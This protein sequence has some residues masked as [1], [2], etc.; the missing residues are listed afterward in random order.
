MHGHS[1]LQ[2]QNLPLWR[3]WRRQGYY[4]LTLATL[5]GMSRLPERWGQGICVGLARLALR[6]RSRERRQA[7]HNLGLAFPHLS[8]SERHRLLAKALETLG[9]NL[10]DMLV[11]DRQA[12]RDFPEVADAGVIASIS[13]LRAHGRG[14]L[15][16]TGHL[17]CWELLGAYLAARLQ[18]LAVITGTVHNAPVDRLLQERRVRL[19]LRPMPRESDLRPVVRTLRRGGVVAVLLDQNTRVQ[20]VAVPFFGRPAPTPVGFAR[21]ALRYRVPVLPVA[22]GRVAA[23]HRISHLSPLPL[24]AGEGPA[25]VQLFLQRCNEALEQFIRRNPAEWV[26]FHDRWGDST[27]SAGPR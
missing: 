6:A 19:G 4:L 5:A 13:K 16:L 3:R 8:P 26:W 15:I 10:Y 18:G 23:G 12:R 20:N 27:G 17:G 9:R 11:L 7:W 24:P 14:V 25:A 21:L 22:I 1:H 2:G